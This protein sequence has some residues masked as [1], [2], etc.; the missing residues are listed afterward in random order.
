M[1]DQAAVEE[2]AD[3][4]ARRR[5]QWAVRGLEA[6]LVHPL[7]RREMVGQHAV[8]RL[9]RL[10]ASTDPFALA[11]VIEDELTRIYEIASRRNNCNPVTS[12][13]T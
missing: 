9:A 2:A 10:G 4:A 5:M 12:Q 6:L 7:E 1:L 13:T 3:R 11:R 8:E